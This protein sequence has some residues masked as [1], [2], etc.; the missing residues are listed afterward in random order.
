MAGT[1]L[2]KI[3]AIERSSK[4]L[5]AVMADGEQAALLDSHILE[6][7]DDL[8]VG[9]ELTAER[10]EELQLLSDCRRARAKAL[11]LAAG[12]ELCRAGVIRKLSDAGYCEEACRYAADSLEELGLVNDE[13]YAE[14]LAE[15]LYS[16][17][18]YAERRV[19]AELTQ[20]GIEKALAAETAA[21]LAPDAAEALDDLLTGR[22]ARQTDTEAG[23]RRTA[24]TLLRYGY[25]SSDVRSAMRRNCGENGE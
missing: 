15:E 5:Y 25:S 24:N 14:M 17:K 4:G 11:N 16:A 3:T 13:R 12:R 6:Q 18:R 23:R 8:A 22:L 1:V 20:R 19:A 9:F 21:R 10:L 2:I 7:A